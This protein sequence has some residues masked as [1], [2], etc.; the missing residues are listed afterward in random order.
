LNNIT[1]NQK[2]DEQ[3]IDT[4][5]NF[6]DSIN[7]LEDLVNVLENGELSLEESLSTFEKGIRLTKECQQQLTM[8][9][10]KIALLTGEGDSMSSVAFT[11]EP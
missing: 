9:E 7:A 3:A 8:A 11:T 1:N 10:Q 2:S 4:R 5:I 6:E